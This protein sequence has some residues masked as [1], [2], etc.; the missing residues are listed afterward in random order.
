MYE[1]N[2]TRFISGEQA[3]FYVPSVIEVDK[4]TSLSFA[5][6]N[7][8]TTS[9]ISEKKYRLDVLK[10]R[11]IHLYITF[12]LYSELTNYFQHLREGVLSVL[13]Q[14]I[15]CICMAY[16]KM[17]RAINTTKQFQFTSQVMDRFTYRYLQNAALSWVEIYKYPMFLMSAF[18]DIL[19]V[20][21]FQH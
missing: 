13:L 5:S 11:C 15:I 20:V 16:C 7:S 21:Y 12:P 2:S 8:L 6:G 9:H 1:T 3:T 4:T 19:H 17:D 14:D 18:A 10:P